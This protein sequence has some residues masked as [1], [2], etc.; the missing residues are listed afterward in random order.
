[1]GM[2]FGFKFFILHFSFCIFLLSACQPKD[3]LI[4]AQSTRFAMGTVI[5]I[6]VLDTT[7]AEANAALEA[8]FAEINRISDQFWEGNP[9]GPIYAFN[10]RTVD[11]V[12]MSPEILE[13]I[14]RSINYSEKLSSAFDITI[15][16]IL[17]LYK[18]KGD[19]LRPPDNARLKTLLSFIDYR[20]LKI[21]WK[22]EQLFAQQRQTMIGMGAVAKGYGVDKAVE[23]IAKH[24]VAGALVN[25]GGDLRVL[26]RQDGRK[27]RVGIQD[28]RQT[29]NILYVIEVDSGAV[30][31]SGDYQKFFMYNNKRVHHLLNPRTGQ[32]AELCQSVTV[33]APS[34]EQADA[35]ATGL[36][37][38][39]T[40]EGRKALEK[41]PGCEVL[42]ICSDGQVMQS[43]GFGKYLVKL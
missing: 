18:F 29:E 38:L 17:P 14:A 11:A 9:Q 24:N 4:K 36:F 21:D 19:S 7:E 15:G 12:A 35:M 16:T 10:H 8:G 33:I 41:F 37:V 30:V 28:P 20:T 40:A 42:W 43:A 13:L 5:E 22:K 2:R 27:W 25:A 34:A 6:T 23:A 32:P 1:M 3:E 26:P 39:G 31:T